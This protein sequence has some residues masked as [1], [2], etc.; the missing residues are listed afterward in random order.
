MKAVFALITFLAATVPAAGADYTE[1]PFLAKAVADG[2]LPPVAARVPKEPAIIALDGPGLAPGRYGGDLRMLMSQPRDTRL[3]VVFGYARLVGYDKS[4]RLVPDILAGLDV[5][6]GRIFTLRLRQGH[7]WSDGAPFT[8]EDFRFYWEDIANN[9]ELSPAGPDNFLR[10]DGQ[11]PK[12]EVIDET[13]IRFTWQ[14]PNPFF[15]PALAGARPEYIFAPA[16]YLKQFHPRYTDPA[17]LASMAAA[18]GQRNW[19]GLFIQKNCQYRNDNPDLPSLEPWVLQTQPPSSYFVFTRNPYY[20][21]VD[22]QGLQLPYVDRVTFTMASPGLIPAKAAAGDADLQA[23]GLGFDNITVLKQGEKR[24]SYNVLLWRTALGSELAIYPNINTIDADYAPL[25]RNADFRRAL[26]LAINREEINQV[27]YTGFGRPGNDTVLPDSPLFK[28]AYETKW[29]DFDLK[30][31]NALL[32][33]LGLDKREG[34]GIRLLPS[35]KRVQMIIETAGEDP[36]EVAILQLVQASWRKAGIDLLVKPE[37]REIMRNRVFSGEAVLAVWTGLENALPNA[38][39]LPAELAP[40]TQQ[41]L[42]WP[43]WGQYVETD[44]HAGAPIDLPAA[45][46]LAAL[47]RQWIGTLDEEKKARIWHEMLSIRADEQFTIGTVRLVPQPVVVNSALRNVPKDGIYN[48]EPG[49]FF[50]VYHPD[51]FWYSMAEPK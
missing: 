2:A 28:P 9:E 48:W 23:R 35:G 47:L 34:S 19:A 10:V 13:T 42:N 40:T 39:T 3:M 8:S 12:F 37:Q 50:G 21:K 5:K 22:T 24:N 18:S 44:G 20:Y 6:E 49:A 38:D 41:Q 30:Q 25:V 43:K 15:L 1:P 36:T 16:H 17:K 29:A 7:R 32:D 46:Q 51:T 27:I 26:S 4:W 31:A 14:K 45:E 11:V 33:R